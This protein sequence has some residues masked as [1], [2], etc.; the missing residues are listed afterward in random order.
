MRQGFGK[1]RLVQVVTEHIAASHTSSGSAAV[2]P[3]ISI[4]P[5]LPSS[6]SLQ[7]ALQKWSAM[8]ISEAKLRKLEGALGQ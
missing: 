5:W 7:R 1:S 8:D 6:I 4:A 2:P 3:I